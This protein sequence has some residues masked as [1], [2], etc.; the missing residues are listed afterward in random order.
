MSEVHEKKEKEGAVDEVG[1]EGE[2][3]GEKEKFG[4]I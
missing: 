3:E 2:K 1:G 4:G